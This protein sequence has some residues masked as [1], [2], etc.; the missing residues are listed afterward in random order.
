MFR[1]LIQ[2]AVESL[3]TLVLISSGAVIIGHLSGRV[4]LARPGT[5]PGMAFNTAVCFMAIAVAVLIL[6]VRTNR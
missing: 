1:F 3:C 4:I 2:K 5:D 6:S